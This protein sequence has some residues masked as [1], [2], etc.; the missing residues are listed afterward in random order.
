MEQI[1]CFTDYMKKVFSTKGWWYI[2]PFALVGFVLAG[3]FYIYSPVFML[4]DYI[5]FELKRLIYKDLEG[6]SGAGQFVILFFCY[7][8][9]M[10]FL[11]STVMCLIPLAIF[12]FLTYCFFFISSLGKVRGN[13]F[14]FHLMK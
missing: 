1:Q 13:P 5:R 4:L 3:L 12:Y 6:V 9:Y 7:S 8:V 10:S 14:A 2:F 11:I